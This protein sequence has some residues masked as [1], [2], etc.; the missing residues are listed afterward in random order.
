[1]LGPYRNTARLEAADLACVRGGREVFSGLSFSIDPGR[2]LFL[3]GPNASGKT[4]LIRLV[5]GLL[6][7]SAGSLVWGGLEGRDGTDALRENLHYVGHLPALK[8]VLSVGENVAFWARLEGYAGGVS[9]ALSAVGL[10]GLAD[11]PARVLSEGQKRRTA[12]ARLFAVPKPLWL[13]DEP[14][15]G[16][17]AAST[18]RLCRAINQHLERGGLAMVATHIDLEIGNAASLELPGGA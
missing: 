7:P 2:A 15:A 11:L 1:M 8:P 13:L 10:A 16:L 18:D 9:S 5:A 12:L 6:Q 14:T 3:R 17:D 4:S